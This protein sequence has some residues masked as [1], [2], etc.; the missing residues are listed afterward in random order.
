M[1]NGATLHKNDASL[2]NDERRGIQNAKKEK[3]N[4]QTLKFATND[5][6]Y[7]RQVTNNELG[8]TA[9][10]RF[11]Q[12]VEKRL[13]QTQLQEGAGGKEREEETTQAR[14]RKNRILR[15]RAQEIAAL[16][17][18][19]EAV[20]VAENIGIEAG[21]AEL[22]IKDRPQMPD[23]PYIIASLALLKDISDAISLTGIGYVVVIATSFCMSIVL[24]IWALGKMDGG[25]W[26]K[27]CIRGLLTKYG[28]AISIEFL[29]FVS[30]VPTTIIFVLMAHYRETKV[31]KIM[32]QALEQLHAKG[33]S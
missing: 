1:S 10:D 32:N 21:D 6:R 14:R 3:R 22:L 5:P 31:V 15:G 9:T 19:L 18:I 23:F 13:L 33:L 12:K 30:I 17:E 16:E 27:R 8:N 20:E 2:P 11:T 4:P 26:K 29:P 7:N 24:F 25:W 28:I